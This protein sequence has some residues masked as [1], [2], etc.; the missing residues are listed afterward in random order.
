MNFRKNLHEIIK[1]LEAQIDSVRGEISLYKNKGAQLSG[2]FNP[3]AQGD[4]EDPM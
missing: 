2:L 1:L 4:F 3:D